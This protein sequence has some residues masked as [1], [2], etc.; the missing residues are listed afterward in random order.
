MQHHEIN[1]KRKEHNK[2]TLKFVLKWDQLCDNI[3]KYKVSNK[4]F[5]SYLVYDHE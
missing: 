5:N 1:V 3:F 4:A 2:L